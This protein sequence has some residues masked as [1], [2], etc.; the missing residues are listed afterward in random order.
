MQTVSE[1]INLVAGDAA[2]IPAARFGSVSDLFL[3][4][5]EFSDF[6][7]KAHH[8]QRRPPVRKGL[9]DKGYFAN[10]LKHLECRKCPRTAHAS[11]H[12]VHLSESVAC[13]KGGAVGRGNDKKKTKSKRI[14][15]ISDWMFSRTLTLLFPPR[16]WGSPPRESE[17]TRGRLE[18]ERLS[19]LSPPRPA[20]LSPVSFS[21]LLPSP[22]SLCLPPSALCFFSSL[23]AFFRRLALRP[24]PLTR[25]SEVCKNI[26]ISSL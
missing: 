21:P 9:S 8:K 13:F 11:L 20:N 7:P 25:S 18:Q 23:S 12:L 3:G 26:S 19:H 6:P 5:F 15:L 24:S 1:S 4:D 14:T 2:Q 17:T 16:A 22:L 10:P